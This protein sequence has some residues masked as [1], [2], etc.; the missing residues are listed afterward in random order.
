MPDTKHHRMPNLVRPSPVGI[1][2]NSRRG[3]H[4]E[5]YAPRLGCRLVA[6]SSLEYEHY[7]L[8]ECD[9]TVAKYE[10]QVPATVEIDGKQRKTVFDSKVTYRDGRKV[11]YE[12]KFAEDVA[13]PETKSQLVVQRLWA[14]QNAYEHVLVTQVEIREAAVYL[15]NC[16]SMLPWARPLHD[17]LPEPRALVLGT[18]HGAAAALSLGEVANRTTQPIET[19]LSVVV[20]EFINQ[21][22]ALPDIQTK[23]FGRKSLVVGLV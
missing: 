8:L 11:I 18:I 9:P 20:R 22:L 1:A 16:H 13:L 5:F 12:V 10:A 3:T 15:E 4:W 21:R 6:A 17:T 14:E 19:V 23:T 7:V 2:G